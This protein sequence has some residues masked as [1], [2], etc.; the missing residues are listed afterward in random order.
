MQVVVVEEFE[1]KTLKDLG[2]KFSDDL[3][4]LITQ[5]LES[6][7]KSGDVDFHE[8]TY[9]ILTVLSSAMVGIARQNG[10][11]NLAVDFVAT[12]RREITNRIPEHEATN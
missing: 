8:A 12:A 5:L 6:M 11:I 3:S 7:V 4:R 10:N 9:V 1:N 2:I